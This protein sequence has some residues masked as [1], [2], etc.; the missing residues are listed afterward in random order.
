[1]ERP[2]KHRVARALQN[3]ARAALVRDLSLVLLAASAAL[4]Q[5]AAEE[6]P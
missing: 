4:S 2:P 3:A 6:V 5:R 1:M